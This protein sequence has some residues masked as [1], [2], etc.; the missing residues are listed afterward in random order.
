MVPSFFYVPFRYT[1]AA[2]CACRE[3]SLLTAYVA[4][5]FLQVAH[6]VPEAQRISRL[7]AR[8]KGFPIAL[9]K[10]SAPFAMKFLQFLEAGVSFFCGYMKNVPFS[11]I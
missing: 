1:F 4:S 9:W 10:P 3:R 8:L 11:T 6:C 5:L 7:R 2:G